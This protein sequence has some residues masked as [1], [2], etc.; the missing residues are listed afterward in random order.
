MNML[1]CRHL[2][3]SSI[4]HIHANYCQI[5]T[6]KCQVC[7]S[8]TKLAQLRHHSMESVGGECTVCVD[9]GSVGRAVL[10]QWVVPHQLGPGLR[11]EDQSM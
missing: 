1:L 9:G 5:R 2:R 4:L 6:H 8:E 10:Q 11:A 7:Y 3:L